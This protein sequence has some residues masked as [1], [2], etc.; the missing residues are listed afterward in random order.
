MTFVVAR[1]AVAGH[2]I[3]AGG[4]SFLEAGTLLRKENTGVDRVGTIGT[5]VD[6]SDVACLWAIETEAGVAMVLV[7]SHRVD[8]PMMQTCHQRFRSRKNIDHDC[9]PIVRS[10]YTD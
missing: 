6:A 4:S 1:I 5:E 9:D 7:L 8:E 3:P 10:N 2:S